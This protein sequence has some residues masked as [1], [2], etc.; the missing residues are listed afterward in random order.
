MKN[1][2][3]EISEG[4]KEFGKNLSIIIN[5]LLLTLVYFIGVG[6]TS[7]IA[8]IF[9]KRFLQSKKLEKDSYWINTNKKNKDIEEFY[10]QF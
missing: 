5:T 6:T 2:L 3:K 10:K 8:K 9:K 4:I 7:I 1:N